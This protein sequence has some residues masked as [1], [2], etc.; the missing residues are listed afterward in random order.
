V[1]RRRA[2]LAGWLMLISLFSLV[3]IA[4]WARSA[5][6]VVRVVWEQRYQDLEKAVQMAATEWQAQSGGQRVELQSVT[7][8][9]EGLYQIVALRSW[10]DLII[11]GA[12]EAYDYFRGDLLVPVESLVQRDRAFFG[13]VVPEEA[14]IWG[15][16]KGTA[17]CLYIGPNWRARRDPSFVCIPKMARSSAEAWEVAKLIVRHAGAVDSDGEAAR[18][19]IRKYFTEQDFTTVYRHLLHEDRRREYT[20][21]SDDWT[22]TDF[23][24]HSKEFVSTL[25]PLLGIRSID[26]SQR[27]VYS[28]GDP[29]RRATYSGGRMSFREYEVETGTSGT[30]QRVSLLDPWKLSILDRVTSIPISF[31]IQ[32]RNGYPVRRFFHSPLKGFERWWATGTIRPAYCQ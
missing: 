21:R 17:Y 27:G 6:K 1:L 9:D 25:Q 20:G 32:M 19:L 4:V 11:T 10:A 24:R 22:E 26:L 12:A 3:P 18:N 13:S 14:Q 7:R 16:Y 2:N 23:I 15:R 31:L 30:S 28:R 8:M 29:L 5:E